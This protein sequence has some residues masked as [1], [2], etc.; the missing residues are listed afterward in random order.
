VLITQP[1]D[2]PYHL[3]AP[4]WSEGTYLPP[5]CPGKV[6]RWELRRVGN[7]ASLR[8]GDE[9][10][11]DRRTPGGLTASYTYDEANAVSLRSRH[12]RPTDQRRRCDVH[13]GQQP[14]SA[15]PLEGGE[16]S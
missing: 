6:I 4:A 15:S 1:Q 8:S 2:I 11:P 16:T 14:P 3:F 5:R 7:P 9:R 10:S 12:E 13:L